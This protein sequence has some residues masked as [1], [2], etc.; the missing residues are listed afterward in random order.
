[1]KNHFILFPLV[2][3]LLAGCLVK[4][5]TGTEENLTAVRMP[6][7]YI[8]NVQFAPLYVAIDKGYYR[9]AGLEVTLDYSRETDSLALVGANELQFAVVSGEQVPM[10]RAQGLP[11]VYVMQWYQRY[12]VGVVSFAEKK[13]QEPIDLRGKKIGIPGLFGASYIGFKAILNAGGLNE[14]DVTLDSIG[15]TQAEAL[16]DKLE[17]AVV[18]YVANE[19]VKLKS[20]GYQVNV[21]SAPEG[22]LVGNGLATN[23]ETIKEKPELVRAMVK[24]TL[25]GIRYTIDHPDEA[26]EI[27]KKY[28]E[29]LAAADQELQ[30]AVLAASVELW[31]TKK[32][33][34]TDQATWERM[35]ELLTNMKLLKEPLQAAELFSND[36]L[37]R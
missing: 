15:F 19:P 4:P 34:F 36:F 24:A 25:A 13:L 35:V 32:P 3:L 16:M 37:P 28:V 21:I 14:S 11:V 27:C 12:P 8:P 9:E 20:E 26:Y 7:G 31:R 2:C 17:D 10:A 22:V 30:K 1:M 23:Q 29:N 18:I 5:L 6:V 33:G